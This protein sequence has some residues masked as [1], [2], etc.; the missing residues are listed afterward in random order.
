MLSMFISPP[1]IKSGHRIKWRELYPILCI[2]ATATA[3]TIFLGDG[4][5]N[6]FVIAL[7]FLSPMFMLQRILTTESV[8]LLFFAS[9]ILIFPAIFHLGDTRW[10]TV[11]YSL[12]FCGLFVSYDHAL[13][14]G[15][16]RLTLF[17]NIIRYLIIAY[18]VVLIIQ[19][20]C[21][22]FGVPIFNINNYDP[23]SP[24]KLNSLSAEP[25]HSARIVGVLM[26][27]YILGS[28]IYIS[29]DKNIII[30]KKQSNFLWV[31]FLW[32]MI[33]MSSATAILMIVIVLLAKAEK[34]GLLLF[35]AT[36]LFL[37]GV[38]LVIPEQISERVIRLTSA[39]LTFDYV[40]VLNADHSGAMR[41]AP[42]L[43]LTDHIEVFSVSGLFG[44]GVDSVG[45]FMSDFI[46]G[47]QEGSSGGGLLAL[48]YEYG[49]ISFLLFVAFSVKATAALNS[50]SNFVVWFV[51]IFIAGV[52]SQM[53]WLTIMLLYTVNVYRRQTVSSTKRVY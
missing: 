52:N 47:I 39:F 23:S 40:Q 28:R 34:G 6:L 16:L 24:W 3:P 48:W 21:V 12:M 20:I 22:L 25:S 53:V 33:T 41:L 38:L 26:F 37:I 1:S 10:S 5:R 36:L 14:R 9:S 49:L 17:L 2:V 46:W 27:S 44:N 7:M 51:L 29:T 8:V 18:T 42:M 19:Q 50:P 15:Y 32:T 11:F 45:S 30:L 35:M 43:V 13:S 4:N 31:C